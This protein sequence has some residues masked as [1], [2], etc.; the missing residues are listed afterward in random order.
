MINR[1]NFEKV[2]THN[3]WGV[4]ERFKKALQR[5]EKGEYLLF[6]IYGEQTIGDAFQVNK[7]PYRDS[8]V[9]FSGG[10]YPFRVGIAPLIV[11]KT[12]PFAL[13]LRARLQF[14][15]NKKFWSGYLRQTMRT[16]HEED[17]ELIVKHL[18]EAK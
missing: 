3:V 4:A 5:A 16:I 14:I 6:Y 11:P 9:V 8:K 2:V 18:E 7:E 12:P 17:Y 10:S 13:E 15:T 1:T